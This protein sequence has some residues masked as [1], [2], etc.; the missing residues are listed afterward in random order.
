MK[1][2][3]LRKKTDKYMPNWE[4]HAVNIQFRHKLPEILFKLMPY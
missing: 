4:V 3:N 1:I 2:I